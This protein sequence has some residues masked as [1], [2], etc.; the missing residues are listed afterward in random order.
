LS[1]PFPL[2]LAPMK[3]ANPGSP[4]KW[5]FKIEREREPIYTYNYKVAKQLTIFAATFIKYKHVMQGE[6]EKQKYG[7]YMHQPLLLTI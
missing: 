3:P 1:P 5:P 2:Y 7:Y 4:G 6:M